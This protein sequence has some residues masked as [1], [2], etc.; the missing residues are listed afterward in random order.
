MLSRLSKVEPAESFAGTGSGRVSSDFRLE[1]GVCVAGVPGD[2][3]ADDS[4]SAI[5]CDCEASVACEDRVVDAPN[6][7]SI[8]SGL[9]GT[10]SASEADTR[11][12]AGRGC[13]RFLR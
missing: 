8:D 2:F 11:L 7:L 13:L 10:V 6:C 12:P 9:A 5:V 4:V 3:D 1:T